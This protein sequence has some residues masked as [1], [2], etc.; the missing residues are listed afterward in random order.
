MLGNSQRLFDYSSLESDLDQECA[1]ELA[2]SFL[3]DTQPIMTRLVEA[4]SAKDQEGVRSS[5]HKLRGCC[6]SIN[7]L[8]VEEESA[9][10]EDISTGGDWGAINARLTLLQPLYNELC[11][12]IN[13]YLKKG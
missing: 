7:A 2:R 5:A 10:L 9:D 13:A 8:P 3:E 12:E 6:R 1:M 4:V 11:G